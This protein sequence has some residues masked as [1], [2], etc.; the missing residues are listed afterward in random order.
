MEVNWIKMK[1]RWWVK[2]LMGLKRAVFLQEVS[3]KIKNFQQTFYFKNCKWLQKTLLKI[4]KKNSRYLQQKKFKKKC[5]LDQ[6]YLGSWNFKKKNCF[7]H[8]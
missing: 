4:F 2:N 8:G 6:I 3:Y 7:Q 5:S 1:I